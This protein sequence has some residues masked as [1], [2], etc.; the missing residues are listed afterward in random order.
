MADRLDVLVTAQLGQPVACGTEVP[1]KI[2][3]DTCS[4]RV[5]R[6]QYPTRSRSGRVP[7]STSGRASKS[8]SARRRRSASTRGPPSRHRARSTSRNDLREQR[9]R[10]C[11]ATRRAV[12]A[13]GVRRCLT[14]V[15]VPFAR[16]GSMTDDASR[17]PTEGPGVDRV[18]SL[19]TPPGSLPARYRRDTNIQAGPAEQPVWSHMLA[20]TPRGV[21][22]GGQRR[23][24]GALRWR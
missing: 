17:F 21:A 7:R 16:R 13:R 12:R 23:P 3:E 10:W 9:R 24:L 11:Q 15:S 5:V 2:T 1:S 4:R 6:T 18:K 19:T 22:D 8:S 20:C 14:P